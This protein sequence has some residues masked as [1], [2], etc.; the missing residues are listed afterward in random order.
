MN[1]SSTSVS[2]SSYLQ[3]TPR[4]ARRLVL[5]AAAV[6]A[7]AVMG[8][9]PAASAA[10]V[11]KADNAD[12]LNLDSSWFTSPQPGAGDVAVWDN[13][14]SAGNATATMGGDLSWSGIR[15]ADPAAT[16]VINA[17]NTLTL[18]AAGID[19][20]AATVGLTLNNALTLGASQNWNVGSTGTVTIGGAMAGGTSVLTK[21]GSGTVVFNVASTGTYSL[22]V[23]AGTIALGNVSNSMLGN[24]TITFGGGNIHSLGNGSQPA[25]ANHMIVPTGVTTTINMGNRIILGSGSNGFTLTGDGTLNLI[26]NTTVARDD[27]RHNATAF[28]GTV[29]YSG[30]GTVRLF[31]N[32]GAFG[33]GYTNAFVNVDGSA[34]LQPQTNSGGNT[35]N[36]GALGGSSATASLAGG[37]AGAP[38]WTIGGKNLSTSFAGNIIGNSIVTKTGTGRLTLAGNSN[39]Y[40]GAT[41]INTGTL[42]LNGLKNGAS[43][44]NVNNGAALGG[45]GTIDTVGGAIVNSGGRLSPG[46]PTVNSGVGTLTSGTLTLAAGS[47]LDLEFGSGVNDTMMVTNSN[48]LTINGGAVNLFAAGTS[49][50]FSTDGTYNLIGYNGAIGGSGVTAL[51]VTSPQTGK[52]YAFGSTGSFVTLAISSGAT[53]IYWN[54]NADGAWGTGGNWTGGVAPDAPGAFANFGGGGTPITAPRT[55][56]LNGSRT[57]G[58]VSF[59]SAQSFTIAQGSGGSLVLDNNG[60]TAQVTDALGSHTISAPVS[61]TAFGAA[62]NVVGASDTLSI[63]GALSGSGNISKSGAGVLLLG[64]NNTGYTGATTVSGGTVQLGHA[65]AL[66][67]S[68]INLTG[69]NLGFSSGVGTFNTLTSLAGSV[70]LTDVAAGPVSLAIGAA[71]DTANFTATLSGAGTLVKNGSGSIGLTANNTNTGGAIVNNGTLAIAPNAGLSGPTVLANGTALGLAQTG[72]PSTFYGGD[73]TVAAGA[74]ANIFSAAL[75]NGFGSNFISGDSTSILQVS[76]PTSAS[77]N[78]A[79]KQFQGFTGTVKVLDGAALRFSGSSQLNNGGDNTTFDVAPTGVLHTRNGGAMSLGALT[80]SGIVRGGSNAAG[81]V[82]FTMGAKNID[83]TFDGQ[84]LDGTVG[85]SPA[86]IVKAGSGRLTLT[87]THGYTGSTTVNSGVLNVGNAGVIPAVATTVN[88][89]TLNLAAGNP[90]AQKL[91][92]L[93]IAAGTGFVDVN[94]NDLVVTNL[95]PKATIEGYVHDGRNNGAWTGSGIT[96]SSARALAT[97]GVGV[98]SGAEYSSVGGTGNFSNQPYAA[99]DTLVKY[100]WNGDANFDGRITFDD[101]VKIDTGFN[102]GLTGWLN[103][104]FNYSGAVNF[105]DYVL[106]DIAFNQQNGTLGRAIDWIS[107]DDRSAAGLSGDAIE[108]MLGH[109]DQFGSAYGAAFLAAVPEPTSLALLGAPVIAG[110]IRRRRRA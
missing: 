102:T 76:G 77:N 103:G 95:T 28:T 68:A 14:V 29:N 24:A 40:T 49:N 47:Q 27:V 16:V 101:Y 66:A 17:G 19:T 82:T 69:G 39:S 20:S 13:R 41:N 15:V 90:N 25:L 91:A 53:P 9:S 75:G 89:G 70:A 38:N 1:P 60:A 12:A 63:T 56:S 6:A 64:G 54:V 4:A 44:V 109:L 57:A 43:V 55:V 10:D 85:T 36:I 7:G 83:S 86:A 18:G 99:D 32:G 31:I 30:S 80:G 67:N 71:N 93:T 23:N 46:D 26:A 108:T 87:G 21:S 8:G 72:T 92:S 88:G 59:N 65:D 3:V 52:S 79:V 34:S 2:R 37:T 81:L 48:G 94:D 11:F 105:D 84:I 74:T 35:I 62:V 61:L 100:T 73:V 78:S 22:N 45:N 50:P 98:L 33:A 42:T 96:S 107:G 5:V 97:T 106:I 104:D 51:T 110:M 58:A